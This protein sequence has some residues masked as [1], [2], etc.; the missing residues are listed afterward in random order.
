M[1]TNEVFSAVFPENGV[2]IRQKCAKI[3]FD[4]VRSDEGK[5]TEIIHP[6]RA[7]VWCEPAGT[8]CCTGPGAFHLNRAGRVRAVTAS[9][10]VRKTRSAAERSAAEAGW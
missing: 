6:K 10:F 8:L 4:I 7:G 5:K 9:S 3:D 2:D 1:S